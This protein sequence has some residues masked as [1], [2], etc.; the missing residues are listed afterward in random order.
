MGELTVREDNVP[1]APPAVPAQ[2]LTALAQWAHDAQ[3][4]HT[5]AQSLSKTQFVPKSFNGNPDNITAAILTGQELGLPPMASLRSMDIIYGVPALRAHAMRGLV[6]SHG[7]EVELVESSDTRCVVRGRRKGAADWQQVTWTIDRAAKLLGGLKDQ[8]VKQPTT[9]LIARATGEICRLIAADV[10]YAAPYAAEE[11]DGTG[12][13]G[14]TY[15]A[16]PVTAG[17]ILG[18]DE[19]DG[20]EELPEV[21]PPPGE[22]DPDAEAAAQLAEET[23][24]WPPVRRPGSGA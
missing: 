8:W 16:T 18:E 22:P 15:S 24:G 11:L 6:Q 23:G 10:L 9:M 19:P 7:H 14:P 21:G 1:A 5:I 20:A 2:E 4:A 12:R 17:E 3:Q 13:P